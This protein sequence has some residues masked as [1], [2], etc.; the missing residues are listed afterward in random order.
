MIN[1]IKKRWQYI[2]QVTTN[3]LRDQELLDI[4]EFALPFK[5]ESAE[6]LGCGFWGCIWQC[7]WLPNFVIKFTFDPLEG[8]A[9]AAIMNSPELH[10]HPGVA[11]FHALWP[12]PLLPG[13]KH[14]LPKKIMGIERN[15]TI[16]GYV[17]ILEKVLPITN[18]E[19]L[20]S[21]MLSDISEIQSA[22][23]NYY[24]HMTTSYSRKARKR[25]LEQLRYLY[26][27]DEGAD[28]AEFLFLAENFGGI[29][30]RDLHFGNIG[31]R[32]FN[33]SPNVGKLIL[34]DVGRAGIA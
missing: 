34:F 12:S 16:L 19:I 21:E 31:K 17:I 4:D 33:F 6:L 5:I 27:T 29:I 18:S 9:V 32:I 1:E 25:W 11:Y 24:K 13:E 8:P 14:F 15:D 20:T 23:S 2:R 26:E 30:I 3:L 7:Q 28:L 22:A 10:R